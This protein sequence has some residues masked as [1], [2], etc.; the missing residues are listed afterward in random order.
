MYLAHLT[1]AT[2][3]PAMT[4]AFIANSIDTGKKP[5]MMLNK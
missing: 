2:K 1:L 3:Q 5:W 4:A